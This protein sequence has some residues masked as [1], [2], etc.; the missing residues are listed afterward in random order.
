VSDF[1]T[2]SMAR[3]LGE[4]V[5]VITKYRTVTPGFYILQVTVESTE[6]CRQKYKKKEQE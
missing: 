4:G 5:R 1:S 2:V 6:W 3:A